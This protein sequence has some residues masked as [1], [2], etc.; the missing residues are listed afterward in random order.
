MQGLGRGLS[1]KVSTCLLDCQALSQPAATTEGYQGALSCVPKSL[2]WIKLPVAQHVPHTAVL[3][4]VQ[5]AV[6]EAK[7]L[8]YKESFR[9]S[10]QVWAATSN[11]T[12][13][14]ALPLFAG[15]VRRHTRTT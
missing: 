13:C 7:G 15:P 8:I 9:A 6:D 5:I 11:M 1:V 4:R 2:H 12:Q 10:L 3:R 14:P